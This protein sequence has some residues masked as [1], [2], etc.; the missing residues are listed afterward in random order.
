MEIKIENKEGIT[1]LTKDKYCDENINIRVD[2]SLFDQD[3]TIEDGLITRTLTHYYN[4]RVESIG[5]R[6]FQNY[7]T[8]IEMEFPNVTST[9]LNCFYGS[10]GIK[11]LVLPKL[12]TVGGNS[13]YQM[14]ALKVLSL[15]LVET[16]TSGTCR[17]STGF[18]VVYIPKVTKLTTATFA[19]CTN[20]KTLII[21]SNVTMD[22]VNAI[23]R[24]EIES[25]TGYIYVPDTDVESYKG[26]TN[27][28]TYADQIKGWSEIPNDIKEELEI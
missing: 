6:V 24:T 16:I 9:G 22:N 27:F 18:E 26:K 8:E 25:G 19:D 12:V 1:L 2:K 7:D 20:L 15:P 13:F 11:K 3:H 23:I 10:K 21:G 17:Y 28:T 5:A 4:D 14:T